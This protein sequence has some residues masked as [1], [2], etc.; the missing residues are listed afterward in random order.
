MIIKEII[1]VE[2]RDDTVAIKRAVSADTIETGGSAVTEQIINKIK[3]AHKLRGVI[4]FTDPDFPGE[5]IR[6]MIST[7]VPGVKHAFITKKE[8]RGNKDIGVENATPEVIKKALKEAKV[9]WIEEPLEKISWEYLIVSGLI[10]EAK[11]RM[12]REA[13]CDTLGIG[14]CNGKQLH[15]R[16]RIFQISEEEFIK[17]LESIDVGE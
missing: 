17:A 7:E 15:K 8:A 12:R 13:L 2:G 5:K 4:I 16:L 6:K 10:G 14:Y 9:E 11:A 3:K 1:V